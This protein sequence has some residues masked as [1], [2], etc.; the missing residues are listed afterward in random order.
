MWTIHSHSEPSEVKS[1]SAI[2]QD[3]HFSNSTFIWMGKKLFMS[4]AL[5]H[6][7]ELSIDRPTPPPNFFNEPTL[8]IVARHSLLCNL[9]VLSASGHFNSDILCSLCHS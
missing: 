3:A 4:W 5:R 2:I 6:C 9:D 8:L 7:T 1:F